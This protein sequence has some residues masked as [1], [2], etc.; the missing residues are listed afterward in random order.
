MEEARIVRRD[1]QR[2]EPQHAAV[3]DAGQGQLQRRVLGLRRMVE[4]L[5]HGGGA[6]QQLVEGVVAQRQR[7]RQADGRPERIPAADPVPELED[8]VRRDAQVERGLDVGG[9]RHHQ[10]FYKITDTRQLALVEYRLS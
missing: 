4:V 9:D 6:G 2:V 1:D 8:V 7:D 10:L 5:V 3:D